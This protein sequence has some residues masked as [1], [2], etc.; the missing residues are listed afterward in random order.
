[1]GSIRVLRLLSSAMCIS[2]VDGDFLSG[3]ASSAVDASTE[4]E[5][6]TSNSSDE[7][8]ATAPRPSAKPCKHGYLSTVKRAGKPEQ[9]SC[10][11]TFPRS[12]MTTPEFGTDC[13]LAYC[14]HGS[15]NFTEEKCICAAAWRHAGI[16]SPWEF[17]NGRCSQHRCVSD[18][19]C[20]ESLGLPFATCPVKGWNCDCG[21]SH[22]FYGTGSEGAQCMFPW[23]ALVMKITRA[24]VA[25]MQRLWLVMLLAAVCLLLVGK[26]V[27]GTME[28]Y[29][30]EVFFHDCAWSVFVLKFGIWLYAFSTVT[31]LCLLGLWLFVAVFAAV[32]IMVAILMFAAAMACMAA[33]GEAGAGGLGECCCGG[34]GCTGCGFSECGACECADC[35]AGGE[36]C[37]CCGG[38]AATAEAGPMAL[39]SY[40]PFWFYYWPTYYHS[41]HAGEPWCCGCPGGSLAQRFWTCFGWVPCFRLL[42]SVAPRLP[43]NMLGGILGFVLGT[44]PLRNVAHPQHH[45]WARRLLSRPCYSLTNRS[46]RWRRHVYEWLHERDAFDAVASTGN[47]VAEVEVDANSARMKIGD[48]VIEQEAGHFTEDDE[49]FNMA[50]YTGN[51]CWICQ[52]SGDQ[53][54]LWVSC[55]HAFCQK[56]S[57]EMLRRRM[58]CPFCRVRSAIVLRRKAVPQ[59]REEEGIDR[60]AERLLEGDASSEPRPHQ[61]QRRARSPTLVAPQQIPP[62]RP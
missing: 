5:T 21:L 11:C 51:E 8:N 59:A 17:F 37:A 40:E 62:L 18:V 56:C 27:V 45:S 6:N 15:Y 4:F 41:G 36:F 9:E 29:R 22:A 43:E 57:V 50:D 58:P 60:E 49:L 28:S 1:M 25:V 44:H 55:R 61:R 30:L 52:A 42:I 13:G 32:A 12:Q 46:D 53:W 10:S 2:Y 31:Y 54:D 39:Y 19:L 33:S 34:D 26:N 38:S 3:D 35:A 14:G 24:Y 48:V 23:W 7:G 20:Q 16:S 47:T